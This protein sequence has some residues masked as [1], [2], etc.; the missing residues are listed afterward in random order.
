MLAAVPPGWEDAF[1]YAGLFLGLIGGAGV[2][3]PWLRRRFHWQAAGITLMAARVVWFT[4][5]LLLG[6][7]SFQI[8]G[9]LVDRSDPQGP[10]FTWFGLLFW[11]TGWFLVG[12]AFRPPPVPRRA[13]G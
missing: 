6:I 2:A 9:R 4:G 3:T 1:V 8:G 7:L 10:V 13:G 5:L 12:W 11:S